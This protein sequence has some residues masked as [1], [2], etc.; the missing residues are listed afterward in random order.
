MAKKKEMSFAEYYH[1]ETLKELATDKSKEADQAR[2]LLNIQIERIRS[3][4]Q[5]SN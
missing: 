1:Q 3:Y 2:I 4:N 5:K